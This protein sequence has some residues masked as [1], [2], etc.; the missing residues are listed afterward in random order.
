MLQ[1]LQLSRSHGDHAQPH[2]SQTL[3][4]LS[5]LHLTRP[6]PV[7]QATSPGQQAPVNSL[8]MSVSEYSSKDSFSNNTS[9][10]TIQYLCVCGC[11]IN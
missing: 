1:D 8:L 9:L 7:S 3:T 4:Q 11:L 6:S 5:S 10:Q 2:D